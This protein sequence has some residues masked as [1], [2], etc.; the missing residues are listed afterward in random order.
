VERAHLEGRLGSVDGEQ[1]AQSNLNALG[2]V[3]IKR[4]RI[5]ATDTHLCIR[6]EMAS[7]ILI[8]RGNVK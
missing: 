5:W 6:H 4:S 3:L 8:S 7:A 1:V 2:T